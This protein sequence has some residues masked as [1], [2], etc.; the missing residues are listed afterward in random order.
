MLNFNK[1]KVKNHF[2]TQ[3]HC[4]LYF[5]GLIICLLLKFSL[6]FSSFLDLPDPDPHLDPDQGGHRMWIQCG[7]GAGSGSETFLLV[8]WSGSNFSYSPGTCKGL[9]HALHKCATT[10]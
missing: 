8:Q 10:F 5:L 6:H 7:S 2:Y 1:N 9:D 3:L 4:F